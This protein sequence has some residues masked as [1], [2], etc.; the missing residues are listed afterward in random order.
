MK[1]RGREGSGSFR[2][3]RRYIS[4]HTEAIQWLPAMCILGFF[5]KWNG[6]LFDQWHV[7]TLATTEE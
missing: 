7:F 6:R 2:G 5:G 4:A 3:L 1:E